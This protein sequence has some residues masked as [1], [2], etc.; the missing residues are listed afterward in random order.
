VLRWQFFRGLRA[1][2]LLPPEDIDLLERETQSTQVGD[3]QQMLLD[4]DLL[5]AY[6]VRRIREGKAAGLVF[7]QYQILDEIGTGGFGQ[8]YKVRHALLDR[9]M[10]LKLITRE[11]CQSRLF[12]DVFRREVAA[13]TRLSHPNVAATYDADEIDG[14]LFLA[15]EYVEGPTLHAFVRPTDPPPLTLACALMAQMAEGVGHAHQNGLVH[16][17]IKPANILLPGVVPAAG[18]ADP[19]RPLVKVIDFGLARLYPRDDRAGVTLLADPGAVVGTPAFMSPEQAANFH[20]ADARSD[21]YSLGCTYYYLLTG[22]LPFESSSSR[23]TLEMHAGQAPKPIREWRPEVPAGLAQVVHRLLEKRPQDR[24]QTAAELGAA[25]EAFV[26]SGCGVGGDPP[27]DPSPPPRS[28]RGERDET[29]ALAPARE[30]EADPPPPAPPPA[31]VPAEPV[32]VETLRRLW[33]EWCVV[34][35]ALAGGEPVGVSAVRYADLYG[36]LISALGR[37][38]ETRPGPTRGQRDRLRTL[39]E[40]WVTLR[41]FRALDGPELAE[42]SRACQELDRAFDLPRPA[43]ARRRAWALWSVPTVGA[44]VGGANWLATH[45]SVAAAAVGAGTP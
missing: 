23:V 29:H 1:S 12:R 9:V 6:Q 10:A 8:V 26:F 17:D 19:T 35:E 44:L 4:Q 45:G 2:K 31:A 7:G 22:R 11:H 32:P 28:T 30:P 5:T 13:V 16:R 33:L 15:M 34:V 21:L 42:L 24:Y 20:D 36:D 14:A 41:S 43:R 37:P 38:D 18:P 40:P 25:M 3:I 39:V 27:A